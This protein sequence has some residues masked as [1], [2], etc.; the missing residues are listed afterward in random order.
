MYLGLKGLRTVYLSLGK[1][2]P[3]IFSKFNPL[4]TDTSLIWTLSMAPSVSILTTLTV[5]ARKVIVVNTD[6]TYA[7]KRKN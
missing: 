5:N 3:Y 1:E 7:V 2:S 6:T 4:S